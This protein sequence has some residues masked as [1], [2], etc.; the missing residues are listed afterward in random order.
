MDTKTKN[1]T[2]DDFFKARDARNARGFNDT[3]TPKTPQQEVVINADELQT[4]NV[5]VATPQP[6]QPQDFGE[7][8][9]FFDE[10]PQD[11]QAQA[12]IDNKQSANDAFL[13]QIGES[14]G[15]QATQGAR[16]IALENEAGIGQLSN[17][18]TDITNEISQKSLEMRRE[19]EAISTEEG[20]GAAQ[21]RARLADV[22]RK[23]SSELAD[24]EVIRQARS[25]TLTNA[26]S[27][28]DRKVELEFG[29][30]ER[31]L[32][33]LKFIY[34]EN[35]QNL[36]KEQD[37]AFQKSLTREQ[38]EFD[39]AKGQFQQL[40]SVKLDVI[41]NASMNGASNEVLKNIQSANN[42]QEV[43]SNAGSYGLSLDE[44]LK[45]FQLNE[46]MSTSSGGSLSE[47]DRVEILKNKTAQEA[48]S[49]IAVDRVL[50]EYADKISADLSPGRLGRKELNAF[51]TNVIAP[52]L[53]VANG[54]G[55]M[56]DDERRAI[57]DDI[58][59]GALKRE[60]VSINNVNSVRS[61]INS[62]INTALDAVDSAYPGASTEFGIFSEYNDTK[63]SEL[64]GDLPTRVRSLS[65]AQSQIALQQADSSGVSID[66]ILLDNDLY[67]LIISQ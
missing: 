60:K 7:L 35:K 57:L 12:S 25:N 22:S 63:K 44:K 23:Q 29:D 40:E 3:I 4:P 5:P 10:T 11:A 55:A 65:D 28:V 47:K 26:Q 1:L 14:F 34:N 6:Q 56:T 17:E 62:K 9:R 2:P 43:F 39:V 64:Y 37:R 46:L 19:R 27:L 36:T 15:N 51:V 45:K 49:L 61:G 38:R 50:K 41:K 66:D 52:T 67:E 18:L 31:R 16:T 13:D 48:T 21:K 59:V 58:G 54:Q 33:G 8:N 30:E 53:A 32:E 20:L 24:L 42:V